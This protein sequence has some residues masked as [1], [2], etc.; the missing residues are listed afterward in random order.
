MDGGSFETLTFT[1]KIMESQI[2]VRG[3]NVD[4]FCGVM[5]L[6]RRWYYGGQLEFLVKS[7][8]KI[9]V[10]L[11]DESQLRTDLDF[12][13]LRVTLSTEDPLPHFDAQEIQAE[14]FGG[15][16]GIERLVLDTK[17]LGSDDLLIKI[18][19]DIKGVN[20]EKI[21]ALYPQKEIFVTGLIDG[22]L[23]IKI[24]ATGVTSEGGELQ[25]RSPGGYI[26]YATGFGDSSE[27]LKL[28]SQVLENFKYNHLVVQVKY[29]KNGDLKLTTRIEGV[30]PKMNKKRPVNV[31]LS[32]WENIPTLL[33]SLRL[34]RGKFK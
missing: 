2:V 27:Q 17:S 28:V 12:Q 31:N 6:V 29:D 1:L 5:E 26:R 11:K 19:T 32:I 34:A 22:S 15:A 9:L 30:N 10:E 23:P 25:A 18:P 24:T 33:K 14:L 8:Q 21:M 20:L 13:S 7:D 3:Y 16:V 4:V